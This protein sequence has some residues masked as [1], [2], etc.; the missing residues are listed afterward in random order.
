MTPWPCIQPATL[1]WSD[2]QGR[3][4]TARLRAHI[5]RYG[6]AGSEVRAPCPITS[7]IEPTELIHGMGHGVPDA[8]IVVK[9]LELA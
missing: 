3:A 4:P 1:P 7:L 8:L 2:D 5:G 6:D 9:R